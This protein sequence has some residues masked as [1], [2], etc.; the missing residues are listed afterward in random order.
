MRWKVNKLLDSEIYTLEDNNEYEVYDTIEEGSN[1]YLLLAEVNNLKNI[2]IRNLVYNPTN[3]EE[4][5]ER[6]EDKKFDE[7]FNKFIQ[8]NKDLFN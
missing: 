2:V 3:G 8:K 5:L 4:H 7:I 1:T 6:L